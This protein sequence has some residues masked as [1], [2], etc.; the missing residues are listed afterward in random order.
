MSENSV[1]A[2]KRKPCNLRIM[3]SR[4]VS[5]EASH[6]CARTQSLIPMPVDIGQVALGNLPQAYVDLP[7]TVIIPPAR[8]MEPDEQIRAQLAALDLAAINEVAAA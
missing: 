2:A 7:N 8:D 4:M 5:R 1:T 6:A 3:L